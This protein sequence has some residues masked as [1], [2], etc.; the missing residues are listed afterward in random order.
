[1]IVREQLGILKRTI[2][3]IWVRWILQDSSVSRASNDCELS[4]SKDCIEV[5]ILHRLPSI[6]DNTI[7]VLILQ[8]L[9]RFLHHELS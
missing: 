2:G 3:Y 8:L 5:K 6:T 7:Y 4:P 9:L 1:M